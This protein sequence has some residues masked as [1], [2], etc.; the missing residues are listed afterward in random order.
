MKRFLW[1]IC[2]CI[3]S[4][5]NAYS[6]EFS[7]AILK[8]EMWKRTTSTESYIFTDKYM[9]RRYLSDESNYD[10]GISRQRYYIG[11]KKDR[12]FDIAQWK[13]Y[14]GR[15]SYL[16]IDA[17][18][19][20]LSPDIPSYK[21]LS[22]DNSRLMLYA[23]P[24]FKDKRDTITWNRMGDDDYD[25]LRLSFA[26][27]QLEAGY[28]PAREKQFFRAFPSKWYDFERTFRKAFIPGNQSKDGKN[29]DMSY[30]TETCLGLFCRLKNI[31]LKDYCERVVGLTVGMTLTDD[32]LTRRWNGIVLDALSKKEA[33]MLTAISKQD[34]VRQKRFWEY[35]CFT[36]PK[37]N[38]K[39]IETI[40]RNIATKDSV[41]GRQL[42]YC[43]KHFSNHLVNN[44]DSQERI[45]K[46]VWQK[47]HRRGFGIVARIYVTDSLSFVIDNLLEAPKMN[48]NNG[49]IDTTTLK[50]DGYNIM[51]RSLDTD[52]MLLAISCRELSETNVRNKTLMQ[53]LF[54]E[55]FPSTWGD[56]YA[57]M[58]STEVGNRNF[59]RNAIRYINLFSELEAIPLDEY[60][61]KTVNVSIGAISQSTVS[62]HWRT[63]V[64][65]IIDTHKAETEKVL[66]EYAPWQRVSFLQF[67]ENKAVTNIDNGTER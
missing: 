4:I 35:V 11:N 28:T 34:S 40:C 12:K 60:I 41:M 33:A 23:R 16:S 13:K 32:A 51:T 22:R 29:T 18:T 63:I 49:V 64:K 19:G 31:S 58:E 21:I 59:R 57:M 6:Q 43:I 50:I 44:K 56:L 30:A 5:V 10:F 24:Y 36:Q 14:V 8:D 47:T 26:Y 45:I 62:E 20:P 65:K 15:G 66:E 46:S 53:Q 67:V 7:N 27:R 3:L 54:F 39:L 52:S 48:I 42:S 55:S 1:L 38:T 2:F 37:N 9:Y 17:E 25:T 61:R